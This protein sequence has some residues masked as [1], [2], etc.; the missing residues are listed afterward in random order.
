MTI[1]K[2]I[3]SAIKIV[4]AKSEDL[5]IDLI[6]E[7]SDGYDKEHAS[8]FL[9]TMVLDRQPIKAAIIDGNNKIANGSTRYWVNVKA[10]GVYYTNKK[11]ERLIEVVDPLSSYEAR[12]IN[13]SSFSGT[14]TYVNNHVVTYEKGRVISEKDEDFFNPKLYETVDMKHYHELIKEYFQMTHDQWEIFKRATTNQ[15]MR[16]LVD[17]C[18]KEKSIN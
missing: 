15:S 1:N 12:K 14:V 4:A 18:K 9:D 17:L 8:M 3:L 16:E 6:V 7:L 13:L 2:N 10:T 11:G 5:A